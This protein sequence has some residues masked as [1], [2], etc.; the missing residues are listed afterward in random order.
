MK[1]VNQ[2]IVNAMRGKMGPVYKEFIGLCNKRIE[3]EVDGLVKVIDTEM[4]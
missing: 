4:A 1:T 2:I 3:K